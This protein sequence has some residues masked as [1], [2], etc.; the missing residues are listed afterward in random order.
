MGRWCFISRSLAFDYPP[1]IFVVPL[2]TQPHPGVSPPSGVQSNQCYGP[3]ASR[4]HGR[5]PPPA[6][7][8]PVPWVLALLHHRT[9]RTRPGTA[10]LARQQRSRSCCERRTAPAL[11]NAQNA[12]A[13]TSLGRAALCLARTRHSGLGRPG[14]R[15]IPIASCAMRSTPVAQD[16]QRQHPSPVPPLQNAGVKWTQNGIGIRLWGPRRRLGI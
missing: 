5:P 15:S 1:P 9:P 10:G 4:P 6:R 8:A 14:S 12:R 7:A 16:L 3:R 2:S 11:H 13:H